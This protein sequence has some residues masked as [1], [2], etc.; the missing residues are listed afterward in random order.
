MNNFLNMPFLLI[1]LFLMTSPFSASAQSVTILGD[2]DDARE[3]YFS[4]GIAIQMQNTSSSEIE[5]C[6]RAIGLGNLRLRD[7]AA[8]FVNR[9]ILY[10]ADEQYQEA[11]K[12]YERAMKLYPEF[13][14][15]YVNRG[16]LFFLGQS[17][18]SA[19]LEYTKALD[20]DL[21]QDYVAYLNR[22]MAYEKLGKLSN[23]ESDYRLAI[24]LAPEWSVAKS[25]LERVLIKIN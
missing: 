19:I 17:Y 1:T 9:G 13:G 7:K 22:G 18:D 12:D 10:A 2:S 5:T 16:N 15:I 23:A 4:A 21:R 8:T 3:C 11:I 14:A 20:L 24:E 25:K 6:S